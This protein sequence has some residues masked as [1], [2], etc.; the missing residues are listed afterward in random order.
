[1]NSFIK[2][3]KLSFLFIARTLLFIVF[4]YLGFHFKSRIDDDI[5]KII[6]KNQVTDKM[7][8]IEI[9]EIKESISSNV[10][11][12]MY[13]PLVLFYLLYLVKTETDKENKRL[14]KLEK[15]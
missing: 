15:E 13:A 9:F 12:L 11:Y 2:Y 8:F 4:I 6:E 10:Y 7:N 14:D 1:M 3:P 5:D